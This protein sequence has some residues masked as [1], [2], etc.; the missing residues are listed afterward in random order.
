MCKT[1]PP[2]TAS[3]CAHQCSVFP[4]QRLVMVMARFGSFSLSPYFWLKHVMLPTIPEA[5]V[6]AGV[7]ASGRLRRLKEVA[8]EYIFVFGVLG[9]K[10]ISQNDFVNSTL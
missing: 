2:R 1:L 5:L 9:L 6:L 8:R 7:N 3:N 4:S 10:E